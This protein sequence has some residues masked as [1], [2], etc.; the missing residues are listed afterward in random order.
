MEEI[1]NELLYASVEDCALGITKGYKYTNKEGKERY[2]FC[3]FYYTDGEKV[4][5]KVSNERGEFY[6]TIE[7][8]DLV[9]ETYIMKDGTKG[10]KTYPL[11]EVPYLA[12]DSNNV[13]VTV[14]ENFLKFKLH[15]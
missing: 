15:R 3:E 2:A 10:S 12:V 11:S 6:Y 13:D 1:K 9:V 7:L 14:L 4:C 8:I 5:R